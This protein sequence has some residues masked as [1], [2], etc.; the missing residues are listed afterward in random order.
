MKS[1]F[2]PSTTVDWI[3]ELDILD[4]NAFNWNCSREYLQIINFSLLGLFGSFFIFSV[5]HPCLLS[6]SADQSV[7]PAPARFLDV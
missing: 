3:L 6:T 2:L 1:T 5:L 7:P 4:K